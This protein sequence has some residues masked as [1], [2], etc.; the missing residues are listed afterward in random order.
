M[1][2]YILIS[3]NKRVSE[4]VEKR[5]LIAFFFDREESILFF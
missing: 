5:V 1:V 3:S 4:S 2:G